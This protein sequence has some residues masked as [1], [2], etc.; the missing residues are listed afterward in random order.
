MSNENYLDSFLSRATNTILS[1]VK[2]FSQAIEIRPSGLLFAASM[3]L[4]AALISFAVDIIFHSDSRAL[5]HLT[6]NLLLLPVIGI[7]CTILITLTVYTVGLFNG[8]TAAFDRAIDRAYSLAIVLPVAAI[9]LPLFDASVF[10]LAFWLA[11]L[12]YCLG[13]Y[14]I[15]MSKVSATIMAAIVGLI[16]L[17][18]FTSAIADKS[19]P[20]NQQGVEAG[21]TAVHPENS[22][23]NIDAQ[24]EIHTLDDKS[25]AQNKANS[26]STPFSFDLKQESETQHING[27]S[28]SLGESLGRV[29]RE[30]R[31]FTTSAT[32]QESGDNQTESVI[33]ES[34][35]KNLQASS[36]NAEQASPTTNLDKQIDVSKPTA[37]ELG[38]LLGGFVAELQSAAKAASKEYESVINEHSEKANQHID[39]ANK[40]IEDFIEG[41][42][43]G[44]NSDQQQPE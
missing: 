38:E 32:N 13:V 2:E 15:K 28:G 16:A 4:L 31:N 27:S 14:T 6:E 3:G 24:E 42:N 34:G 29:M 39:T 19:A 21:A 22:K 35:H 26:T 10:I 20:S 37:E 7:C 36:G 43:R 8:A 9:V 41:Y 44:A 25:T 11:Y 18:I 17:S 40:L 33:D 12:T 23:I 1:P 30:V 5:T